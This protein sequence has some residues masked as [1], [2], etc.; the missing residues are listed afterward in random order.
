MKVTLSL[1][2]LA[3]LLTVSTGCNGESNAVAPPILSPEADAKRNEEYAKTINESIS[4][5]RE[6]HGVTA[7]PKG[8]EK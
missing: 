1:L 5:T 7:A 8:E 2:A 4:K 3:G 6:E